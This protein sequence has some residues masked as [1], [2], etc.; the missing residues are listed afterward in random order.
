MS[1]DLAPDGS[2]EGIVV[3]ALDGDHH[4]VI[5]HLPKD[6]AEHLGSLHTDDSDVVTTALEAY[7]HFGRYRGNQP[8]FAAILITHWGNAWTETVEKV[9]AVAEDWVSQKNLDLVELEEAHAQLLGLAAHARGHHVEQRTLRRIAALSRTVQ[10][11]IEK[12]AA[13]FHA[14]QPPRRLARP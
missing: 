8:L 12:R 9:L 13:W 14:S 5:L 10:N 11:T 7:E 6:T 2:R 1:D 4:T 3:G